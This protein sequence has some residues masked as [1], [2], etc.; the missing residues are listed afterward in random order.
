MS[1]QSI[2]GKAGEFNI[3]FRDATLSNHAGLVLLRDFVERLGV[4]ELL[5]EELRVKRR[6]RGHPQSEAVL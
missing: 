6:E 1:E 2:V 4:A 3:C 5:G